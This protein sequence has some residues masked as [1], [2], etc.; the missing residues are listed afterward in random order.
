MAYVH[1][2]DDGLL[3][4]Q[5]FVAHRMQCGVMTISFNLIQ[6]GHHF[7]TALK[8]MAWRKYYMSYL[9]KIIFSFGKIELQISLWGM[10]TFEL[11]IQVV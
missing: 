8:L 1:V 3:C 10:K 5:V 4:S 9:Q 7:Y 11:V 2:V 6:I